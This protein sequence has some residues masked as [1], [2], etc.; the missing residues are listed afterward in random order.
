[1]QLNIA[2]VEIKLNLVDVTSLKAQT[3][4]GINV[5]HLLDGI[6]YYEYAAISLYA[7]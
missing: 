5:N 2:S 6:E 4:Q 7:M 3:R 1:M